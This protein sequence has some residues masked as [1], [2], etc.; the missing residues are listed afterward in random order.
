MLLLSHTL[1]ICLKWVLVEDVRLKKECVS[2]VAL[3]LPWVT[4]QMRPTRLPHYSQNDSPLRNTTSDSLDRTESVVLWGF[5]PNHHKEAAFMTTAALSAKL[6]TQPSS[7]REISPTLV[8]LSFLPSSCCTETS[9]GSFARKHGTSGGS[10]WN[11]PT[12]PPTLALLVSLEQAGRQKFEPAT[13]HFNRLRGKNPQA[14]LAPPS[15]RRSVRHCLTDG[16]LQPLSC[17]WNSSNLE[18]LFHRPY[19]KSGEAWRTRLRKSWSGPFSRG[20]WGL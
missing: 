19:P 4:C 13:I 7:R 12:A 8:T 14:H 18:E 17:Q 9:S 3:D 15:T 2:A 6:C 5:P 16:G 11:L 1:T 20:L 10:S